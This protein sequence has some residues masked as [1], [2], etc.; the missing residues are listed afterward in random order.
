[1]KLIFA[2]E[3]SKNS[4]KICIRVISINGHCKI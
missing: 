3:G 4:S 2:I 1:M